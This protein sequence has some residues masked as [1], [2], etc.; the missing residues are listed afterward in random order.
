MVRD[1]SERDSED[2]D[3][4]DE[5]AIT[6]AAQEELS[7]LKKASKKKTQ[8]ETNIEDL[9]G[10][11]D[12]A[13]QE[14][15]SKEKLIQTKVN[16]ANQAID[17]MRTTASSS[18]SDIESKV[19]SASDKIDEAF[20]KMQLI[21]K[22]IP[23]V[24]L[25]VYYLVY[26]YQY[27]F[28]YKPA[29]F[30]GIAIAAVVGLL[31]KVI[32]DRLYLNLE[33]KRTEAV[34]DIKTVREG[35]G[36]F[37]TTK[38]SITPNLKRV[39]DSFVDA[40][41]YGK[42][43]MSTMRD[44]IPAL[45]TAYK[46]R[47][48]LSRQL[49]FIKSLRNSLTVY[50][51]ELGPKANDY[52]SHFGPLTESEVEWLDEITVGLKSILEVQPLLL[53]MIYLDYTSDK[54]ALKNVWKEITSK[55]KLISD[56]V[57]ILI[58]N[59]LVNTE[60]IEKNMETYGAIE[61]LI[62][63]DK[64]FNLE[65]FRNK[66]NTYYTDFANEKKTIIDGLREY[67]F[68]VGSTLEQKILKYTPPTFEAEKRLDSIFTFIA[69]QL[70]LHSD[71]VK[72]AYFE[73][74]SDI[75]KRNQTWN[76][77][78]KKP[79]ILS[80]FIMKLIDNSILEVPTQYKETRLALKNFVVNTLQSSDDFSLAGAK[81]NL[82]LAF[83]Y[84]EDEK[85]T[86]LRLLSNKIVI[87]RDE[88]VR[89]LESDVNPKVIAKWIQEHTDI[90][91]YVTLL[92]YYDYVQNDGLRKK[93][94]ESM[95]EPKKMLKFSEVLIERRFI[96]TLE[97]E[98]ED[99][100]VNLSLLLMKM[101]DYDRTEIQSKFFIYN[102]LLSYSKDLLIFLNEQELIKEEAQPD[103][104]SILEAVKLE[105]TDLLHQE[106]LIL[107]NAIKV[108]CSKD[109]NS[110]EWHQPI[111][112]ATLVIYLTT[113]ESMLSRSACISAGA[114]EKASKILYQY[115]RINDEEL[116]RG[117]TERT[118]FAEIVQNTIDGTYI[119]YD[120]LIPF[121]DELT[122][123]FLYTRLSHLLHVRL[124]IIG[125]EFGDKAKLEKIIKRYSDATN[126]FLES[127]IKAN[128]ILESLRMQLI[129]AYMI[130]NPSVGAV[131]TGVI[132]T[133]MSKACEELAKDN[134]IYKNLLLLSDDA[135]LGK[136]TR[137]GIV[138]FQMDFDDFSKYFETAFHL[139]LEKHRISDSRPL[140]EFSGNVIRMFPSDAYFKRVEGKPQ[141]KDKLSHNHPVQ[142]IRRLVLKY[143]GQ[144]ENLELIAS[145]SGNAEN[146]IAMRSLL[147]TFFDTDTRIYLMAENQLNGIVGNSQFIDYLKEGSF[148]QEL[149]SSFNCKTRSQLAITIYDSSGGD[150][151]KAKTVRENIKIQVTRIAKQSGA[152]LNSQQISDISSTVYQVLYD[153]GAVLR[154]F[155]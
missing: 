6:L 97:S 155:T 140:E 120:Y 121:E 92:L 93:L 111:T 50:G 27:G 54:E 39:K 69:E 154:G 32:L 24:I 38:L 151:I 70:G 67:G 119:K 5:A 10:S 134:P 74:E 1:S 153:I 88:F 18:V 114:N 19:K 58:T 12:T 145:L 13:D 103:L 77:I 95:H 104:D 127:K 98:T 124:D 83:S 94:F 21:A 43:V 52:L 144:I 47:E 146:K 8:I 102:Q 138:P 152:R 11:L 117:A 15:L 139:A 25:A 14:L 63:G 3:S 126:T 60:Y 61:E 110:L 129:N 99:A 135:S 20:E 109:F 125:K 100:I 148:D 75:L 143:Y 72:L 82:Q 85:D 35:L 150:G 64:Q 131:I 133:Q 96:T 51:F 45:E 118:Y 30:G 62:K 40:A 105:N 113:R 17:S 79:D 55:P 123:G 89:W 36:G 112:I 68:K 28:T 26:L 132:D 116:Q 108:N 53:K 137:I 87:N 57:N 48:R 41:G 106:E 78:C 86:F 66:Y 107:D 22:I 81:H 46:S 136:G 84:L 65:S 141:G 31:L 4:K 115:S 147:T 7:S 128:V 23:I 59:E 44:Y 122:S 33:I 142:I 73:R 9:K 37:L 91:D 90:P 42:V 101:T 16:A 130:T 34:E 49:N 71:I 56:L 76:N 149:W 29:V 80:S 2:D